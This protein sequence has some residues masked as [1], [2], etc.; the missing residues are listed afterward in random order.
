MFGKDAEHSTLEA[1]APL[2]L[3][4]GLRLTEVSD[5]PREGICDQNCDGRRRPRTRGTLFTL[6]VVP[7]FYSLIGTR[8]QP[9]QTDDEWRMGPN[10]KSDAELPPLQWSLLHDEKKS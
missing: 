1:C 3:P 4:H 10:R 6:F 9:T 5:Q 2:F 7:V 8:H